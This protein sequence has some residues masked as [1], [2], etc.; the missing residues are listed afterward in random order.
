MPLGGIGTGTVSL[1]GRGDL[2]DWEIMNRPAKGFVPASGDIRP[3]FALFAQ[4]GEA[5]PICRILEGPLESSEYEGSHGST[6][7]SHNLPRFR[8]A[9][10]TAAYPLG[11]VILSDPDLPV[12][13]HLK[14]FNPLVPCDPEAS[15]IPI[16]ILAYEI[17]NRT[18]KPVTISVCG[19]LPNFI[20]MDGWESRRD[21]KG[22]TV[23]TGASGNRNEYRQTI[24]ARG[25]FMSSQ[26]AVKDAA[27]WGTIALATTAGEGLSARTF[28]AAEE[29]GNS[30]LDFWD[31]FSADGEIEAREPWKT[32]TPVA[33]LAVR[34]TLVPA[35]VRK[36]T[37]LLAW[38]FP[39]RYTWT[40]RKE[41]KDV[42]GL[43][44]FR[45]RLP[46]E[47]SVA[48]GEEGDGVLLD[49]RR[50]GRRPRRCHGG[51][52]AQHHGRRILRTE[53]AD[54]RLVSRCAARSP[55]NGTIPG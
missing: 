36:I 51:M 8:H 21:W 15:G 41:A 12:E 54:D 42:S 4:A 45:Q 38:H 24:R 50:M 44:A 17:H 53:S 22:D 46:A 20:G 28:W 30:L 7:P 16:A 55:G 9:A 25:I 29:W 26:G 14:A 34:L 32:D 37:F 33:S 27:Q 31:D 35:A 52:P 43:A 40:A 11:R 6:A 47:K 3:F 48:Q 2:R 10:F 18:S 39:N 5:S 1:G 49:Q 13:V 19:S 23:Y